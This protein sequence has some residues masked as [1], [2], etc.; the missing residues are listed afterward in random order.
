MSEIEILQ[1]ENARLQAEIARLMAAVKNIHGDDQCHLANPATDP[2]PPTPEMEESCRRF[3]AQRRGEVGE[4][5]APCMTIAQ[6]EQENTELRKDKDRLDWLERTPDKVDGL[7]LLS[8]I[9]FASD[10]GALDREGIDKIRT[11]IATGVI[12]VP[13]E[14]IT[15]SQRLW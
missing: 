8:K 13:G 12:R 1:E 14:G 3:I 10:L 4:L 11:L 5:T 6:L 9:Y 7:E 2:I 15:R